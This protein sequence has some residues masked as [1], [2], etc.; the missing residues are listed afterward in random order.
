MLAH[1]KRT[2]FQLAGDFLAAATGTHEHCD[3]RLTRLQRIGRKPETWRAAAAPGL[4][5]S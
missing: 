5:S 1:R 4:A 2:D 3:L